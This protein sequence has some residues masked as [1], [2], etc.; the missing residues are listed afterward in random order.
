MAL[1]SRST[2][3]ASSK[4]LS[5]ALSAVSSAFFAGVTWGGRL[6]LDALVGEERW[7]PKKALH[8]EVKKVLTL[9]SLAGKWAPGEPA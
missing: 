4:G 7:L 9:Q 1:S 5:C 8:D 3:A 6:D 2:W